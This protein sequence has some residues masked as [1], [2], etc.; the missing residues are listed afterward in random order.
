MNI[1]NNLY[2]ILSLIK[3]KMMMNSQIILTDPT[4]IEYYKTHPQLDPNAI[5]VMFI[6]ILIQLSTNV[7][8]SLDQSR[9]T[10]IITKL[11]DVNT[12]ITNMKGEITENVKSNLGQLE[13]IIL[14]DRDKI[15]EI[16]TDKTSVLLATT[17]NQFNQTLTTHNE[18]HKTQIYQNNNEIKQLIIQNEEK[19]NNQLT[20]LKD[21]LDTQT[22]I[23]E[24]LN[25]EL[26]QFL[27]KYKHNSSIKG[28]VSEKELYYLLQLLFPTDELI[29]CS[30]TTASCD[31]CVNRYD[32]NKPS[33]LFENKDYINSVD[34]E[35]IQK[36]ERDL[37]TQKKHGIFIS[38]NSPI[39]FKS[40]YHID[41]INGLI[42]IYI[43]NANYD[44]ERIKVAVDI[45]D[46]L[47][48]KISTENINTYEIGLSKT[49]LDEI[50][51]EYKNFA[52]KK[53][54]L[55]DSIRNTSKIWI[56]ELDNMTLPRIQTLLINT[57]HI[58]K[59]EL[60]CNFCMIFIGK[61][62][63]S[64]SAHIKGCKMNHNNVKK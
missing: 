40:N 25:A 22:R 64:L 59:T 21:K 20:Q 39:T 43:P 35:E 24:G 41:I 57:G 3:I 19:H 5:N 11:H 44:L 32:K 37:H 42:H 36:F 7:T 49:E 61:N 46:H 34:K 62:K 12:V 1:K 27:N 15:S 4:V 54:R 60:T 13:N 47:S 30:K 53:I 45:I 31:I 8:S 33:I 56:E 48:T 28:N 23:N 10:Q 2:L 55:L 16:L 6:N 58:E 18:K 14:K 50:V 9:I 26:N 51:T 63:A 17:N 52:T 29:V 38:Q